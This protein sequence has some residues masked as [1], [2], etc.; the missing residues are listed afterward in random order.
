MKQ[1]PN[2]ITSQRRRRNLITTLQ[3]QVGNWYFDDSHICT[4][5]NDHFT[6]LYTTNSTKS[7]LHHLM[8]NS[9]TITSSDKLSLLRPLT[10]LEI[11]T[12]IRSFQPFKVPSQDGLHSFFYQ[13]YWSYVGPKVTNFCKQIFLDCEIPTEIN[14]T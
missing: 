9:P 13:H 1:I 3:D 4:L 6:A 10:D 14:K 8:F 2:F 12:V 5:I 11:T 7:L